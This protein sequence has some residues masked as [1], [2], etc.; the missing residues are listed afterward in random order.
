VDGIT[1][2]GAKPTARRDGN[3]CRSVAVVEHG[4]VD[5]RVEAN[6]R[7]GWTRPAPGQLGRIRECGPDGRRTDAG[8]RERQPGHALWERG[9][10]TGDGSPTGV[11]SESTTPRPTEKESELKKGTFIFFAHLARDQATNHP[12]KKMNVPFF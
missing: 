8:P 7:G 9:L 10:G 5:G 3:P 1:L 6:L 2:R 4:L 11:G 12:A